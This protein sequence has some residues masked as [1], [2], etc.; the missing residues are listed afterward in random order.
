[1]PT[2]LRDSN[3]VNACD[4]ARSTQSSDQ[5]YASPL[6]VSGPEKVLMVFRRPDCFLV[7]VNKVASLLFCPSWARSMSL[8]HSALQFN[9]IRI[10]YLI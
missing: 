5:Y 10:S 2:A 6:Q 3:P 1:V 4:I 8:G 7:S 9:S